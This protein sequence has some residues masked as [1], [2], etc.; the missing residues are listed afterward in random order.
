[1]L[2]NFTDLPTLRGTGLLHGFGGHK[3]GDAQA[4]NGLTP[5][6]ATNRRF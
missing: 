4:N 1:M 2:E 3:G 5:N 6:A